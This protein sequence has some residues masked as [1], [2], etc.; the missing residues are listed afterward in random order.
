MEVK[1]EFGGYFLT[2][3]DP[4]KRVGIMITWQ[5]VKE[6]LDSEQQLSARLFKMMQRS[7]EDEMMKE[8][9]DNI[10]LRMG[11]YKDQLRV[12]IRETAI[13]DGEVT[14]LKSGIN[15]SVLNF[16][17]VMRSLRKEYNKTKNYE[18]HNPLGD[19]DEDEETDSPPPS[20]KSKLQQAPSKAHHSKDGKAARTFRKGVKALK[21][22]TACVS[23]DEETNKTNETNE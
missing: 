23:S 21:R 9:S 3:Y 5:A 7:T 17:E 18:M 1:A 2:I 14:F 16:L 4:M 15:L 11:T 8:L 19:A 22:K 13:K 20:K 12:D 10:V 6:I